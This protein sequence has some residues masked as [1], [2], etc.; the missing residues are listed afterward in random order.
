MNREKIP[1]RLEWSHSNLNIRSINNIGIFFSHQILRNWN[2]GD[3][4]WPALRYIGMKF[5]AIFQINITHHWGLANPK[6]RGDPWYWSHGIVQIPIPAGLL[7]HIGLAI[8][9]ILPI[10]GI[11]RLGF[12]DIIAYCPIFIADVENPAVAT[13]GWTV[14]TFSVVWN[15]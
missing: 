6:H 11:A 12:S 1:N 4:L 3:L 13:T 15:F 9:F 7:I 14:S 2:I 8:P 10:T 5:I